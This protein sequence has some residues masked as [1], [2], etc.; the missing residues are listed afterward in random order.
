MLSTTAQSKTSKENKTTWTTPDELFE[1]QNRLFSFDLDPCSSLENAKCF[2]LCVPPAEFDTLA[3]DPDNIPMIGG[4]IETMDGR[5]IF[6]DG[7]KTDWVIDGVPSR[8]WMNPPYGSAISDWLHKAKSQA[9]RG[10]FTM[11]L[12]P[13]DP[14]TKWWWQFVE[15]HCD[16]KMLRSRVRFGGSVGSPNFASGLAIYWPEDQWRGSTR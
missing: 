14:S 16:L 15:G 13:I 1:R 9:A 7:L 6:R 3:G 10:V 2:R 4:G 8:V 11:A 5:M 12:I